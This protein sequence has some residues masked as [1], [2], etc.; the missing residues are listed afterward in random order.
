MKES[1]STALMFGAAL[2][3]ALALIGI[4]VNVFSPATEAAKAATT[5]F[6]SATTELKD[7]KYLIYDNTTISG[8]QVVNALRKFQAEGESGNIAINVKTGKKTAGTWYFNNFTTAGGISS[9]GITP[10][11]VNTSTDPEYV[12]PSGMFKATVERDSNN[13]IRAILFVQ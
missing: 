10:D 13:V 6:S 7:Q 1:T 9:G 2:F 4:S 5:D 3:L 12:N 8:A 11:K